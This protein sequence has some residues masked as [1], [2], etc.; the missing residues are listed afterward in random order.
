MIFVKPPYP[1]V[2]EEPAVKL[3]QVGVGV[4]LEDAKAVVGDDARPT[5][6]R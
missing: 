1:W 5:L 6:R 3:K 2:F 4:A